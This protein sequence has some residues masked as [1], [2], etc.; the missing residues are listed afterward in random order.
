MGNSEADAHFD[1]VRHGNWCDST[2]RRRATSA[3]IV[4]KRGMTDSVHPL[5]VAADCC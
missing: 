4:L 2:K 3:K 5:L 1:R